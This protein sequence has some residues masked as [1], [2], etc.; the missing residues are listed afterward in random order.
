MDGAEL[1]GKWPYGGQPPHMPAFSLQDYLEE[2]PLVEHKSKQSWREKLARMR[3]TTEA[4]GR[5]G[6]LL[7]NNEYG[8]GKR[9]AF[10]GNWS[11]Y[12]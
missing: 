3:A 9:A 7:M 5:P 6:F 12:D 8:L 4:L 2:F 1:H 11:R 10:A